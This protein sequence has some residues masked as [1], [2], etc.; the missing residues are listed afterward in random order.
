MRELLVPFEIP[1]MPIVVTGRLNLLSCRSGA[2][3]GLFAAI[4]QSLLAELSLSYSRYWATTTE[5]IPD[6]DLLTIT[7]EVRASPEVWLIGGQCKGHFSAK[8]Q[9]ES[10]DLITY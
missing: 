4:D 5:L 3:E 1:E 10:V 7:F 8:V 6:D 2:G 9:Y